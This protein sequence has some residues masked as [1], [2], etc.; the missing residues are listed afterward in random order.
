MTPWAP[1]NARIERLRRCR[2]DIAASE[3][4]LSDLVAEEIGKPR[5]ETLTA[6]IMP[7]LA[8]CRWLERRAPKLLRRRTLRGGGLLGLGQR[9]TESRAPLGRVVIIATWNYP[10]GLLGVQLAHALAAGNTV[11]VKPSEHAPR[12]QAALLDLFARHLPERVLTRTEAT[13]EAGAGVLRNQ[14]RSDVDRFDHVVF[15]GSTGVGRSIAE[16]LA[17]SLTPSTLELSG[18]DSAFV[19]ADAAPRLAARSIWFAV[20]SNAGQTCMAPRRALVERGVYAE[21][22]RELGLLAGAERPRRL[23]AADAAEHAW[24]RVESALRA[25]GRTITGVTEP[26]RGAWLRPA[27]VTECPEHAELVEG[28]H[29]APVLAVVPVDDLAHALAIHRRC[30]QHLATSVFTRRT[31]WARR[32]L[33]P[34]LGAHTVTINDAL[35]PTA[36]P[37]TSIGG[38]GA[39]GW[40]ESRGEAGLRAMT[41]P[42]S[43]ASTSRW[44]RPPLDPPT[45][46]QLATM[47]RWVGRHFGATRGTPAEPQTTDAS[48]TAPARDQQPAEINA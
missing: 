19:L 3:P 40:G 30:D 35:I 38:V 39:S 32:E 24:S 18:R 9:H 48:E 11:V 14:Q 41:R 34:R 13:R 25:G 17:P 47:A 42:V 22:I 43:V 28:D 21:F 1:L 44:L 27:A 37:A 4:A 7:L 45:P 16:T 36:H 33:A 5:H 8:A 10:I 15:T 29:F 6:E 12:T 20:V 2:A 26:P 23:I 46:A 31:G